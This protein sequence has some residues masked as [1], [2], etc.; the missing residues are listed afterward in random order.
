MERGPTTDQRL[1]ATL[2]RATGGSTVPKALDPQGTMLLN[3]K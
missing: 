1:V 3:Y 2:N